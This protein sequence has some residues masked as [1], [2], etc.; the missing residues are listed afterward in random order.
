MIILGIGSDIIEIK[1][2]SDGINRRKG[3]IEKLFSETEREYFKIK[4]NN[5]QTIAGYFCAKEA[6]VKSIGTGFGEISPLDVAIGHYPNGKP[7]AVIKKMPEVK[8]M[9]SISHCKE[10][11]AAN[12]V[13]YNTNS[14]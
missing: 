4:N 11:A 8:F 7:Y 13:A 12:A 2:I 10:Y 5:P 6:V 3:F 9:I 14:H 1:R